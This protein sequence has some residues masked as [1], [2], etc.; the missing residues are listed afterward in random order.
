MPEDST[1]RLYVG[2]DVGGTKILAVA[3][4]PDGEILGRTR[5]PTPPAGSADE[6]LG[7]IIDVIAGALADA[8]ARPEQLAGIGLAVAAVVDPER[9]LIVTTPNL[10][11]AGLEVVGPIEDRFGVPVALGN[12]VNAGTLGEKWL[13]AGRYV[14]NVLGMFIGTGIGGGVV[15]EGHLVRGSRE[16]AGEIGHMVMQLGGPECGCG[17]RGCLEALASRT[18]IE[19]D[20]RVAIGAGRQSS[21]SDEP[22]WPDVRIRSKMIKRALKAGDPLIT[23]VI[24]CAS[25]VIG[26]ACL[27]LRHAFD[28]DLIILGGG[29]I[30]A[31]HKYMMPLIRE[32]VNADPLRGARTSGAVVRS[33]LGDNAVV[34]GA[35]ALV[36][37]EVGGDPIERADLAAPV[38]PL[39]N[40]STFGEI[41][42]DGAVYKGDVYIR[43]DGK[44]KRR[45]L[46]S[47]RAKY[48]SAHQIGP[49]ELDKICRGNPNLVIIGMGHSGLATLTPE[50]EAYLR[51]RGIDFRALPNAKAIKFYNR[52]NGRKAAVVHV[53]C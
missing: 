50:G 52:T 30:E 22:G 1:R 6:A 24:H 19:R 37:A 21:I 17:S 38:Y 29:V 8:G 14:Q 51:R 31:C 23:E 7:A 34:L 10:D 44:V 4:R 46:R 16:L 28:S 47:I 39:I 41:S 53:T 43:G 35:V 27:N 40:Y 9:G 45:K 49:E 33:E 36:Q 25:Q 18:A 12:D 2:V 15:V 32:V 48:G 3:A 11:L 42:L 26:L 5:C 13:G 20:I